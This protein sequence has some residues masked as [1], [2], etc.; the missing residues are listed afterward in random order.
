VGAD[1]FDEKVMVVAG[2]GGAF[3]LRT[4]LSARAPGDGN[5]ACVSSITKNHYGNLG[6][7]QQRLASRLANSEPQ[8]VASHESGEDL[9][10]GTG[11]GAVTY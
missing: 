9:N 7:A 10:L 11:A 4:G 8:A 5:R 1:L 2:E 6:S 3:A